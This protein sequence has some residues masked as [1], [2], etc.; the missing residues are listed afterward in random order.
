ML[1]LIYGKPGVGKTTFVDGTGNCPVLWNEQLK[2]NSVLLDLE[3]TSNSKL[4]R[5]QN[6]KC[7]KYNYLI[8]EYLDKALQYYDSIK[9]YSKTKRWITDANSINNNDITIKKIKIFLTLIYLLEK[10]FHAPCWKTINVINLDNLNIIIESMTL[11]SWI[12]NDLCLN[13]SGFVVQSD[14]EKGKWSK[15]ITC[16]DQ[17]L[18]KFLDV[19][20]Q[21]TEKE[22]WINIIGHANQVEKQNK[23]GTNI[24]MNIINSPQRYALKIREKVDNIFYLKN[25]NNT[26]ELHTKP[27]HK[28]EIKTRLPIA[29]SINNFGL[30]NMYNITNEFDRFNA[31]KHILY[32]WLSLEKDYNLS[33]QYYLAEIKNR[34]NKINVIK[35]II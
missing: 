33:Y 14:P 3:L 32:I 29:N 2:T 30:N 13:K 19:C 27:T 12:E 22:K 25:I 1:T 18:N 5:L 10:E 16:V 21:L 34:E 11:V 24:Y 9:R 20:A 23:D 7:R 17:E 26:Y 31:W 28:T 15:D 4:L 8:D 6:V 35:K